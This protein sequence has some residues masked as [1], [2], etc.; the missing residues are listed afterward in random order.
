MVQ[1]LELSGYS[2]VWE[3]GFGRERAEA[4]SQQRQSC[5]AGPSSGLSE[6]TCSNWPECLE[7][8]DAP[9]DVLLSAFCAAKL[10]GISQLAKPAAQGR[11]TQSPQGSC[12]CCHHSGWTGK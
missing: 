2:C 1:K 8:F 10:T 7:R 9:V 12:N 4:E 3:E 5:M 11:G 6:P